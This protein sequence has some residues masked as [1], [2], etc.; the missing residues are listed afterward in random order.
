[1]AVA[2]AIG[3]FFVVE[4]LDRPARATS[5][6]ASKGMPDRL[7]LMGV[8]SPPDLVQYPGKTRPPTLPAAKAALAD[9]D[10]VLGVLV[11]GKARAYSIKAL[12]LAQ[13]HVVN[14]LVQDV[15]VSVTYCS[16]TSCAK[17]FTLSD[18]GKPL[19]VNVG[20]L[21]DQRLLVLIKGQLYYQD[22][23]EPYV[24]RTGRAQASGPFPYP[25]LPLTRTTWK[26]WKTLHPDTDVYIGDKSS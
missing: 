24:D 7:M 17:A 11:E 6:P 19:E 16:Y 2:I 12:V 21:A 23:L 10:E 20:G 25:C 3:Y 22:S 8:Q 13:D 15:P 14:D 5:F 26:E 9:E 4:G 1:V 18:R